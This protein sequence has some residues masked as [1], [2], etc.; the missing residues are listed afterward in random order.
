MGQNNGSMLVVKPKFV[1]V[2]I[3]LRFSSHA[4]GLALHFAIELNMTHRKRVVSCLSLFLFCV[5]ILTV[6]L[7]SDI[8]Y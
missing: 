7:L 1:K 6:G 2:E 8:P 4:G 3:A 5:V